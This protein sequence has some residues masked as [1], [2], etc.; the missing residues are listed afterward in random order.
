MYKLT[1]RLVILFLGLAVIASCSEDPDKPED[2]ISEDNY[3]DLIVE[4]QLINTFSQSSLADSISADSLIDAT[5]EKYGINREQFAASHNY[6]QDF[7]EEQK[8]RIDSAIERLRM[9]KVQDEIDDT[10]KPERPIPSS[11]DTVRPPTQSSFP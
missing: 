11:S 1:C 7:P 3:I 10:L 2:L 6:Y 9:D 5:F 8:T 4:L